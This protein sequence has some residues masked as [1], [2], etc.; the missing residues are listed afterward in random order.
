V[1][2][3]AAQPGSL[4][5]LQNAVDFRA[6]RAEPISDAD[7]SQRADADRSSA[8]VMFV[9]L[10]CAIGWLLLGSFAGLIASIKLHEPDWLTS[11]AWLIFGRIRTI[12]LNAVIYGWPPMAGV[13]L[14]MWML[15][16]LLKMTLQGRRFALLGAVLWNAGLIA[17]VGATAVG[18]NTGLEWL[19]MPWWLGSVANQARIGISGCAYQCVCQS[20]NSCRLSPAFAVPLCTRLQ[21]VNRCYTVSLVARCQ[22]QTRTAAPCGQ[23]MAAP[24]DCS[25]IRICRP[26]AFDADVPPSHGR[27]PRSLATATRTQDPRPQ[28]AACLQRR[29]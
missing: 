13:G 17:G 7:L 24:A 3:P 11:Y 2:D 25:R 22:S 9:F 10:S 4:A 5:A 8:T 14:A 18:L 20:Q 19:E 16:R 26:V 29:G 23:G 1:K 21:S 12:H 28:E 27:K 15:P 6:G